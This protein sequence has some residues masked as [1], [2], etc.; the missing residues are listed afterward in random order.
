[1]SSNTAKKQSISE[2]EYDG[3]KY[4]LLVIPALNTKIVV[5]ETQEIKRKLHLDAL[6]YDLNS[7]GLLLRLAHYGVVGHVDLEIQVRRVICNAVTICDDTVHMMNEFERASQNALEN[8]QAAYQCLEEALEEDAIKT[9]QEVVLTAQ[10]MQTAANELSEKC[11]HESETASKSTSDV[12]L[13]F[14]KGSSEKQK[15][16]QLLKLELEQNLNQIWSSLKEKLQTNESNYQDSSLKNDNLMKN[17]LHKN[18]ETLKQQQKTILDD[19][20]KS[21][22]ASKIEYKAIIDSKSIEIENHLKLEEDDFTL[23][24]DKGFQNKMITKAQETLNTN[25]RYNK[26]EKDRRMDE[27]LKQKN[28]KNY[29]SESERDLKIKAAKEQK[30]LY[31]EK[32]KSFTSNNEEKSKAITSADTNSEQDIRKAKNKQIKDNEDAEKLRDT[33][34]EN[35]E[36]IKNSKCEKA[37]DDKEQAIMMLKNVTTEAKTAALKLNAQNETKVLTL[38][39][40]ENARIKWESENRSTEQKKAE[41]DAKV[42]AEKTEN[43]EKLLDI[44]KQ[45]DNETVEKAQKEESKVKSVYK[46]KLK[47][48]EQRIW[49]EEMKIKEHFRQKYD[50]IQK[51]YED[52]KQLEELHHKQQDEHEKQIK[53][54]KNKTAEAAQKIASF[55]NEVEVKESSQYCLNE[56]VLALREIQDIMINTSKFWKDTEAICKNVTEHSFTKKVSTMNNRSQSSRK[57]LWGSKTFKAQALTYY[58]KWVALKYVCIDAGKQL[59]FAQEDVHKCLR[60]NPSPEE[61]KHLIKELVNKLN[62]HLAINDNPPHEK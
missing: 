50:N 8:M 11:K 24:H 40:N 4:S 54:A 42:Y 23:Q 10:K 9:L 13:E 12:I 21:E 22:A 30:S 16:I 32:V 29:R 60:E 26:N 1:M 38:E 43:N 15:I 7:L 5:Q 37:L 62:H 34:N 18:T 44:K 51:Q 41:A 56:A 2:V 36:K 25:Q 46:M 53:I 45:S 47:E 52:L 49:H 31:D 33:K 61:A 19:Q 3:R 35:A 48:L 57:T 27:A 17:K 58:G 20:Q 28:E 59:S 55:Q 6:A 39:A 14:D